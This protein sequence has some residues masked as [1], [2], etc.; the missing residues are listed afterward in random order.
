VRLQV[1]ISSVSPEATSEIL[2]RAAKCAPG[3]KVFSTTSNRIVGKTLAY[4]FTDPDL[5]AEVE[6]ED[7]TDMAGTRTAALIAMAP[8]GPMIAAVMLTRLSRPMIEAAGLGLT[9]AQAVQFVHTKR[10]KA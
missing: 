10:G 1:C 9:H 3:V 8:A 6:L 2:A 4:E 7:D 5:W